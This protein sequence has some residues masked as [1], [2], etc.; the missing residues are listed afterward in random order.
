MGSAPC[1]A[2]EITQKIVE[3][4]QDYN[5]DFQVMALVEDDDKWWLCKRSRIRSEIKSRRKTVTTP[6]HTGRELSLA[7]GYSK[8]KDSYSQLG[9]R[10]SERRSEENIRTDH[11]QVKKKRKQDYVEDGDCLLYTSDAADE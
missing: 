11:G 10:K 1:Y 4:S 8:G 9:D 3:Y 5:R 2:T 7:S 6:L